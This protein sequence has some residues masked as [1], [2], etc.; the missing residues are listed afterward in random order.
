[1]PNVWI[2][3]KN[4]RA[5]EGLIPNKSIYGK[6]AMHVIMWC[7]I[8]HTLHHIRNWF[9]KIPATYTLLNDYAILRVRAI[10]TET[11]KHAK[12]AKSLPIGSAMP[13]YEALKK[14]YLLSHGP[15]KETIVYY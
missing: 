9:V 8:Y 6:D 11:S 7:N 5:M 1:M 3:L 4:E 10:K 14:S 15:K 2:F 13:V 12:L